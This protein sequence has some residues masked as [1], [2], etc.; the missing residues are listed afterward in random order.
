V[1]GHVVT[2]HGRPSFPTECL[3]QPLRR[4]VGEVVYVRSGGAVQRGCSKRQDWSFR[5][6]MAPLPRCP[7]AFHFVSRTAGRR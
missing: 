3:G 4:P 6:C 5:Y 2:R 1:S 7:A